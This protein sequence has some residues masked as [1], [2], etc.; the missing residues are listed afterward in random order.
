MPDNKPPPPN[1]AMSRLA[2][3]AAYA[4]L[5]LLCSV[6]VRLLSPQTQASV[7]PYFWLFGPPANL[8]HGVN[9][10]SA[11]LVGSVVALALV[12]ASTRASTAPRKVFLGVG[13]IVTWCFFGFLVYAPGA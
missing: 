9:G 7:E 2:C 12:F 10:V 6:G 11:F 8:V 3:A 5:A 4:V 13:A 1:A